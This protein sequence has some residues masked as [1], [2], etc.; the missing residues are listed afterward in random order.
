MLFVPYR[1]WQHRILSIERPSV[2]HLA[3]LIM[4][5]QLL[6]PSFLPIFLKEFHNVPDVLWNFCLLSQF[7]LDLQGGKFYGKI[8]IEI[9]QILVSNK[10]L[11]LF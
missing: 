11:C 6:I 9:P 8:F 4:G 5:T 10:A 1:V 3:L 7:G 2:L